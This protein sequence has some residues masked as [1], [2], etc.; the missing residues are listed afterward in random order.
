MF[1]YQLLFATWNTVLCFLSDYKL[2]IQWMPIS[3]QACDFT[4]Y[5]I[6]LSTGVFVL[7]SYLEVGVL[8]IILILFFLHVMANYKSTIIDSLE[9]YMTLGECTLHRMIA[10]VIFVF[11]LAYLVLW[12]TSI[13]TMFLT[14][15][16]ASTLRLLECKIDI[17]KVFL[18]TSA[19][20]ITYWSLTIVAVLFLF[21]IV[22]MYGV[23]KFVLL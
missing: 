7:M 2:S 22:N 4:E 16:Y 6:G 14:L 17:Q 19:H 12:A 20:Y 8:I 9:N 11:V 15:E 18:F 3:N 5:R 1:I 10:L 23:A 13:I 21:I